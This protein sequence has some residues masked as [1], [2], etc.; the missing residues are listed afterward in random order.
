MASHHPQTNNREDLVC[1]RLRWLSLHQPPSRFG[2]VSSVSMQLCDFKAQSG[3]IFIHQ[4]DRY[5]AQLNGNGLVLW[6]HS[7][8][9]QLHWNERKCSYIVLLCRQVS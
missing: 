4:C 1:L 2:L 3:R 7:P 8:G 9:A 6:I 5:H